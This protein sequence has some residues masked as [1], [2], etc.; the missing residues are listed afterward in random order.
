MSTKPPSCTTTTSMAFGGITSSLGSIPTLANISLTLPYTQKLNWFKFFRPRFD[1]LVFEPI[2]RLVYSRDALI[3]FIFMACVIDYLSG[4]WWGESTKNNVKNSYTGFVSKYFPKNKYDEEGLYDS[5]RNGLVHMFTIKNKK[6]ALTH[7]NPHL[8]L[9]VKSNQLILNAGDFFEDLKTAKEKYFNEVESTSNLL[10]K[11]VDR[12]T[13]E[14]F[15]DVD[16]L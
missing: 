3:G 11:F 1:A 9:T 2:N 4:F 8:H 6:Y 15:L 13:R 12:Y 5:L 7:N 14:G 16:S 10:D